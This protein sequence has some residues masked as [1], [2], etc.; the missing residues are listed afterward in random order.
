L[1]S[2][3]II[4]KQADLKDLNRI[5]EINNL[6]WGSGLGSTKEDFMERFKVFPEGEIGAY[7]NSKLVGM[8]SSLIIQSD[9]PEDVPSSW[10]EVSDN[11]RIRNSHNHR[12]NSLVCFSVGVGPEARGLNIGRLLVNAQADLARR[13]GLKRVY[14]YS[15]PASYRYFKNKF[16]ANLSD[17][18]FLKIVPIQKYLTLGK[19]GQPR[20]EGEHL[21]D[22]VIG[23]HDGNGA[24]IVR[25]IP[26]GRVEDEEAY[27]YNVLLEYSLN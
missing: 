12:G 13:L 19:D 8:I 14:A 25:I 26:K 11:G 15:R 6:A 21:F 22:P 18:E 23:M 9:S 17:E 3:N 4:I 10:V 24:K 7:L 20:K 1:T 2:N 5:V 16:Y 27:G